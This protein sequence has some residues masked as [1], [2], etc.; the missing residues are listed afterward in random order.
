M[1]YRAEIDGLRAL[2]VIPVI[3]FHAGFSLFSGGFVGVDIF[4]VISGYLITTL[5]LEENKSGKFSIAR[6]YERRARRIL[7]VLFLVMLI[8]LPIAWHLLPAS[9]FFEFFQSLQAVVLF[10]SNHLFMDKSGYFDTTAELKPLLHTWSL[11]VEE[12][13][14]ALFPLI[15]IACSRYLKI[16]GIK[17]VFLGIIFFSFLGSQV[18][19][20]FA[21]TFNFFSLPTRA[22]ELMLGALTAIS[23]FQTH[24]EVDFKYAQIFAS[25][26]A[27]GVLVAITCFSGAT[28][29]P[30]FYALVPTL[31]TVLIIRYTTPKTL[32][33]VI[34]SSP[35]FVS[36][37]LISYSLYLIHQPLFVFARNAYLGALNLGFLLGLICLSM[38]LAYLSWRYVEQPF[39]KAGLIR[40]K[41]ILIFWLVGTLGFL[42]IGVVGTSMDGFPNRF[43]IP[44]KISD[45]FKQGKPPL[46]CTSLGVDKDEIKACKYGEVNSSNSI[47]IG[48]LGDSHS[49]RINKLLNPLGQELG[50]SYVHIGLGGC[51]PLIGVDVIKGNWRSGVCKELAEQQ[52]KYVRDNKIKKIL[53][54][55]RW[56]LYTDRDDHEKMVSYFLVSDLH[57][58]LSRENSRLV[59]A[60]QF[61]KTIKLYRALGVQVF[62][63]LQPPQQVTEP[64]RL[65]Q[66]LYQSENINLEKAKDFIHLA[67]V[68]YPQHLALQQFN[69]E[70]FIET[71]KLYEFMVLNPDSNFCFKNKCEL[72]A[73]DETFYSDSNHLSSSGLLKIKKLIEPIFID[74]N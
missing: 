44:E 11:A 59:F 42:V 36:L 19:V 32:V 57:P 14:Y 46:G 60:E 18:A 1:K 65:Y 2:A 67:S 33:G 5:I 29:Y 34:L 70:Y 12:Q 17:F 39:R 9:D 51:P 26:G 13:Y 28:P 68:D 15:F 63:L 53:L 58:K 48:V 74:K 30:S 72:G 66:K 54:V 27:I 73:I 23:L 37:G 8:C 21:P 16:S 38:I 64:I 40:K 47:S 56:S 22:W 43:H 49:Q 25:L 35:P 55:A 4:F 50:F 45:E 10:L 20:N 69:R 41:I 61:E 24:K 71:A 31:S 62:V 7:P 6:F 52:F 3:F